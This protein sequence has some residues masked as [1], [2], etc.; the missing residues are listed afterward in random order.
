LHHD[1]RGDTNGHA[2]N[3]ANTGA[4]DFTEDHDDTIAQVNSQQKKSLA[5]DRYTYAFLGTKAVIFYA[6]TVAPMRDT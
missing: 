3:A 2:R 1:W 4:L 5:K 6:A